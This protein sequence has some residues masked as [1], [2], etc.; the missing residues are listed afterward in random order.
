MTVPHPQVDWNIDWSEYSPL[1][2]T[3]AHIVEAVWADPE[4][5]AEDF[6]PKWNTLDGN[7]SQ[8]WL[9]ISQDFCLCR[10]AIPTSSFTKPK[11]TA[12]PTI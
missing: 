9:L 5:G 10:C 1:E 3:A 12:C 4:L 7:V 6:S 11:Q 8:R 2:F